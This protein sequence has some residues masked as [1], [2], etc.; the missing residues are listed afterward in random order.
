MAREDLVSPWLTMAEM[1]RIAVDEASD[2]RQW[3]AVVVD[4][5]DTTKSK[6]RTKAMML[7][8]N[9]D[10][11]LRPSVAMTAAVQGSNSNPYRSSDAIGAPIC[12]NDSQR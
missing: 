3:Q 4:P 6:K 7:K 2:N 5:R 11:S 10:E 8:I 9:I 1:R 12:R